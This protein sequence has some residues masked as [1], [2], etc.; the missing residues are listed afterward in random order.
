MD[1]GL[2]ALSAA[3]GTACHQHQLTIAT[4]E[5]CTGGW[6]AQVITHTAG[7][8]AW[9]DRGFVTYSNAAKVDMLGVRAATLDAFGAV[10]NETAIEMATGA[11][12]R[13]KADISLSITGIA[14]P[15]GGSPSKPV[16]TVSF[17][18]CIRGSQAE[19]E[20]CV[21]SGDRESIRR[22][23]V[24]HGL[25]GLLDRINQTAKKLG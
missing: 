23:A 21:F 15:S 17:A 3:L 14:G 16:G 13:S 1:S 19:A 5:S 11:L 10:S 2:I 12:A 20:Q 24:K 25:Q 9:F 18:W 6:A 4:A 7:S 8:S 22:A